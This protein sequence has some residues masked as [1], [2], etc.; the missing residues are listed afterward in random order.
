MEKHLTAREEYGMDFSDIL[1]SEIT[2]TFWVMGQTYEVFQF[3]L[4]FTQ[5]TDEKGEPQAEIRGGRLMITLGQTVSD[6]IYNWAMN[7]WMQKDGEVIFSKETGS[8]PL[9][10]SFKRGYCV[11]FER[12]IDCTGGGLKTSLLISPE[13][14]SLNGFTMNNNWVE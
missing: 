4:G 14:I 1:D 5:P 6:E 8:S 10:I 7:R 12:V 13:E 3:N 11:H 2:V 9:K